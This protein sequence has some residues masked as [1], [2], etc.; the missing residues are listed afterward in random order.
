MHTATMGVVK[1]LAR[2]LVRTGRS[3]HRPGFQRPHA[4]HRV[5]STRVR[6]PQE[7]QRMARRDLGVTFV[8]APVPV[9]A[10]ARCTDRHGS[11]H[12]S[13]AGSGSPAP[14]VPEPRSVAPAEHLVPLVVEGT[15]NVADVQALWLDI[16][17]RSRLPWLALHLSRWY[18]PPVKAVNSAT[19]ETL[20]SALSLTGCRPR[21]SIRGCDSGRSAV[22]RADHVGAYPARRSLPA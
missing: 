22:R 15:R 18:S 17:F 5:T 8:H 9:R 1:P 14:D 2:S 21:V 10:S 11:P 13:G 16:L 12:P 6:A 3:P 20:V 19:F 4:S 7:G